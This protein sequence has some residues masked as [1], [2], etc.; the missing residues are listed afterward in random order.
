MV[1]YYMY[2]IFF[3]LDINLYVCFS[4]LTAKIS[5]CNGKKN[6]RTY[7]RSIQTCY[8]VKVPKGNAYF[9]ISLLF[10]C[11]RKWVNSIDLYDCLSFFHDPA[12]FPLY[13]HFDRMFLELF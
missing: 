4:A 11:V 5:Y 9:L 3:I 6:I 8:I 12:P 13:K 7:G 10:S 2:D 1:K